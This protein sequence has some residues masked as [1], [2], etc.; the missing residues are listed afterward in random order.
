MYVYIYIDLGTFPPSSCVEVLL[1]A[2]AAVDSAAAG[3]QTSLYL[4][5][6]AGRLDCVRVLLSAGADRSHTT[7]VRVLSR[8]GHLPHG[9]KHQEVN[10]VDLVQ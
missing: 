6:E 3:G 9:F 10:F 1:S 7:T 8:A 4:A 2:G 5:C